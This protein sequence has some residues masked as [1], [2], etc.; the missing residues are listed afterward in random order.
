METDV[1]LNTDHQ[2]LFDASGSSTTSASDQTPCH[3]ALRY[4]TDLRNRFASKKTTHEG[5]G[6][7]LLL[8][9]LP[10]I[11]RNAFLQQKQTA[12]ALNK[13]PQGVDNAVEINLNAGG[14]N[15]ERSVL[16][17][18]GG[19]QMCEIICDLV[20]AC[21]AFSV[22]E[23]MANLEGGKSWTCSLQ[24]TGTLERLEGASDGTTNDSADHLNSAVCT[25][26]V[27]ERETE[28]VDSLSSA[29]SFFPSSRMRDAYCGEKIDCVV[30]PWEPVPEPVGDVDGGGQISFAEKTRKLQTAQQATS[31][32][33][34]KQKFVDIAEGIKD[35]T[36]AG[37][38]RSK[39]GPNEKDA[40]LG[41][42]P[43]ALQKVMHEEFGTENPTEGE[44][45]LFVA[46]PKKASNWDYKDTYIRS[47]ELNRCEQEVFVA[48]LEAYSGAEYGGPRVNVRKI[49]D[50][51]IGEISTE[52]KAEEFR[53]LIHQARAQ[54]TNCSLEPHVESTRG[55][56]IHVVD[57]NPSDQEVQ[58][59]GNNENNSANA[60][61]AAGEVDDTFAVDQHSGQEVQ[62]LGNNE[63]NSANANAPAA[64]P[65]PKGKAY[66][67]LLRPPACSK[68]C[69]GADKQGG[70][71]YV[72]CAQGGGAESQRR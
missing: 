72:G 11:D 71:T 44:T 17:T 32:T 28:I 15:N 67:Q 36:Y 48:A 4:A 27:C 13:N 7:E 53:A 62:E 29:Q 68:P 33:T 61:A 9:L 46:N 49:P 2:T 56:V 23:E 51:V 59:P 42:F 40:F 69:Q 20:T 10:W 50:A 66:G 65:K 47:S 6:L 55:I 37:N 39:Y 38:E 34:R 30:T 41:P 12:D 16:L 52:E 8:S 60:P 43:A 26:R 31:S 35:G 3:Q 58:H 1:E 54:Q 19:P 45:E 70:I 25:R 14:D 24:S 21:I 22:V 57:D 5:F 64:P 63:N 18:L